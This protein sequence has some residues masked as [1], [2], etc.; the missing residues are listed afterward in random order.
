[1]K[2]VLDNLRA[3]GFKGDQ[4][5]IAAQDGGEWRKTTEQ[6]AGTFIVKWIAAEHVRAG[7]RH[8]VVCP[9]VTETSK[10]MITQSKRVR[11]DS[12]AM[13]D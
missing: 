2:C 13:V 6:G 11:A 4:S 8:A 5:T 10:G 1:M 12:L 7:Q 9:N 3:F